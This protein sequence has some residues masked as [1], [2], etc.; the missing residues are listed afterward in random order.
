MLGFAFCLLKWCVGCVQVGGAM[1]LRPPGVEPVGQLNRL[2]CAKHVCTLDLLGD[3]AP[4]W[5]LRRVLPPRPP[6]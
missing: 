6:G 5:R 2:L 3:A 1:A 4:H